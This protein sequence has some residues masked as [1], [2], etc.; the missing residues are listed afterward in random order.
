MT[1]LTQIDV[2]E[3]IN[4]LNNYLLEIYSQIN[5][6][7]QQSLKKFNECNYNYIINGLIE[8]SKM[9]EN[10]DPAIKQIIEDRFDDGFTMHNRALLMF[11]AN[12]AIKFI[13]DGYNY[14]KEGKI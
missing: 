1:P 14:S 10:N 2:E 5:N 8:F 13:K 12:L 3:L 7:E 9:I 6:L 11:F 4:L